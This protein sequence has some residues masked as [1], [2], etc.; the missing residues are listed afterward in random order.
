M[1]IG[2]NAKHA[3]LST[4]P[5]ARTSCSTASLASW[6]WRPSPFGQ[7]GEIYQERATKGRSVGIDPETTGADPWSLWERRRGE[8]GE[9][10]HFRINAAEDI[11]HGYYFTDST[12]TP[13][14][15]D[16]LAAASTIEWTWM[17][18]TEAPNPAEWVCPNLDPSGPGADDFRDARTVEE[19]V[20]EPLL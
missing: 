11:R 12:Q 9:V 20:P 13:T 15:E 17:K 3:V 8:D 18:P 2:N 10:Q 14:L 4:M 7:K 1:G 5:R 16:H 19:T 6:P